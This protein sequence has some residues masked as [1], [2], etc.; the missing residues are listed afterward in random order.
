MPY[1]S[2]GHYDFGWNCTR[3]DNNNPI[4]REPPKSRAIDSQ[5][6]TPREE[7]TTEEN[8]PR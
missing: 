7:K 5:W 3:D 1:D 6:M 8:P 4:H 2:N